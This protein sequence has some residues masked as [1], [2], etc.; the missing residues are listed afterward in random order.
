MRDERQ[1]KTQR[2]PAH[3]LQPAIDVAERLLQDLPP[4]HWI[5]DPAPPLAPQR[6]PGVLSG[7]HRPKLL[8]RK[9]QRLRATGDLRAC[10]SFPLGAFFDTNRG[11]LPDMQG[12]PHNVEGAP[13]DREK[14]PTPGAEET[15][16]ERQGPGPSDSPSEEKEEDGQEQG[17]PPSQSL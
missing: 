8:E 11:H 14:K 1:P 7:D 5:L 15:N 2:R 3:Q 10:G 6:R 9:P 16:P 13:P 4:A 17:P 12:T